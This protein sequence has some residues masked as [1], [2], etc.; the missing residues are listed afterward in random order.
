MTLQFTGT[1]SALTEPGRYH[2]SF[3][4]RGKSGTVLIDAG[5][6]VSRALLEQNIPYNEITTII[7]TH[8]HADHIS[9]FA[10][11]ITQ[12]K[13]TGRRTRLDVYVAS[14]MEETLSWFLDATA[15]KVDK[16][17]F[18]FNV[19]PVTEGKAVQVNEE[20][21]VTFMLN[22]HVNPG[23]WKERIKQVSAGLYISVSGTE[24][25]YTSDIGSKKDL[26]LYDDKYPDLFIAEALHVDY[27]EVYNAYITSGA[28]DLYFTHYDHKSL[29]ELEKFIS[30]KNTG[31]ENIFIAR[32]GLV[33]T[34]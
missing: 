17:P 31:E 4:L 11:L 15:R 19:I 27:E 21:K 18:E 6:S 25:F 3:C 13:L 24:I 9:G 1:S 12:M 33:I 28:K 23:A 26:Y 14:G 29:P 16:F 32:D 34:L 22:S 2:S 5:D 10:T 8:F 20:T 7:I 30:A